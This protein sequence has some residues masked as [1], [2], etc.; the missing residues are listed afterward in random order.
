MDIL[1]TINLIGILAAIELIVGI[2]A[3][4]DKAWVNVC[5]GW[6]VVGLMVSSAKEKANLYISRLKQVWAYTA[7]SPPV[8]F[9]ITPQCGA[10][11]INVSDHIRVRDDVSVKLRGETIHCSAGQFIL[12]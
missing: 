4:V 7:T 9:L 8:N 5:K 3:N 10:L 12:A 2:L 6:K 11:R 1:D